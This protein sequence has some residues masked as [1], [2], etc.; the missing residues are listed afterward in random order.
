MIAA[1]AVVLIFLTLGLTVFFVAIRGGARGARE[2]LHSQTPGARRV[3]FIG[4]P[5][6]LLLLTVLVPALVLAGN[7]HGHSRVAPGGI[8]LSAS[9]ARGRRLFAENCATCHTLKAARAV[10]KVGPNLDVLTPPKVL[11]LD[12]I[13]KGRA[14]GNGQMPAQLLTGRD[15]VEVASFVA[16]VEGR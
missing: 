6:L 13:A 3:T 7:D 12:A 2:A 5:I 16:Q 11:I 4:I 1:A 15:A 14:R 9:E 8:K 10:G